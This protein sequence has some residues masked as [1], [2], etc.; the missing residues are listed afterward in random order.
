MKI[1]PVAAEMFHTYAGT[2]GQTDMTMPIVAFFN[3]TD[4]PKNEFCQNCCL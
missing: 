1:R 4:A 2:D 3:F